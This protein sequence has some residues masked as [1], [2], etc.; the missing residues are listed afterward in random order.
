M[1]LKINIKGISFNSKFN[2]NFMFRINSDLSSIKAKILFNNFNQS[3]TYLAI[4]FFNN[5]LIVSKR[6]ELNK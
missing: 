2:F 1:E 4:N 5:I 3:L 6:T